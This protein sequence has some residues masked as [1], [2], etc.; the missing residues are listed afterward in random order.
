MGDRPKF[1]GKAGAVPSGILTGGIV[2][3][4]IT[5]LFSGVIAYALSDEKMTWQDAGYWIM[6]MLFAASYT[7]A[8]CSYMLIKRQRG[9]VSLMTGFLYWGMLL[10]TTALFFGGNYSSLWET[11]GIIVAGCGCA[12]LIKMPDG[13]K[14]GR[15]FRRLNC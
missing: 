9:P 14:R 7:G 10:C 3:M 11:V 8:K 1:T 2:S 4:I 13:K 5:L 6:G 12:V 15:R